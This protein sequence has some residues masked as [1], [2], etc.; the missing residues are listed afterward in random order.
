MILMVSCRMIIKNFLASLDQDSAFLQ[1]ED[2]QKISKIWTQKYDNRGTGFVP[3]YRVRTLVTD[4][5]KPLGLEGVNSKRKTFL[6]VRE[7]LRRSCLYHAQSKFNDEI[8]STV[9]S[10]T[11]PGI[12]QLF[13]S[14]T[15]LEVKL[16]NWVAERSVTP[17]EVAHSGEVLENSAEVSTSDSRNQSSEPQQ[18][19]NA[20]L[21][22]GQSSPAH[23]VS[24]TDQIVDMPLLL[25]VRSTIDLSGEDL[26]GEQM[27]SARVAAER[28]EN[29]EM[30]DGCPPQ[31]EISESYKNQVSIAQETAD[32]ISGL[33]LFENTFQDGTAKSTLLPALTDKTSQNIPVSSGTL[34]NELV[35]DSVVDG[36]VESNHH[37]FTYSSDSGK[38]Q[39][40]PM[41]E[42]QD[43]EK[44]IQKP[45]SVD[46]KSSSAEGTTCL[47]VSRLEFEAEACEDE[48]TL[49]PTSEA[50]VRPGKRVSTSSRDELEDFTISSRTNIE[51]CAGKAAGLVFVMRILA[52]GA[53]NCIIAVRWTVSLFLTMRARQK[54]I[55]HEIRF[56]KFV[57][58]MIYWN[59]EQKVIP[60]ELIESRRMYDDS[61]LR[62]AARDIVVSFLRGLL[63][64]RRLRLNTKIQHLEVIDN[65]ERNAAEDLSENLN[66]PGNVLSIDLE[67]LK[68]QLDLIC[69]FGYGRNLRM[70]ANQR[71]H[72]LLSIGEVGC[73]EALEIAEILNDDNIRIILDFVL[74][75]NRQRNHLDSKK[76]EILGLES[77]LAQLNAEKDEL[78]SE[79]RNVQDSTLKLKQEQDRLKSRELSYKAL[80]LKAQNEP[81][82][83][84]VVSTGEFTSEKEHRNY[85]GQVIDSADQEN[86]QSGDA[87]I[88]DKR[89]E[90][91]RFLTAKKIEQEI[92]KR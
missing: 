44:K 74:A 55:I 71:G 64:R 14:L 57:N 34:G 45:K 35:T 33:A 77:D 42:L 85:S 30:D 32:K 59:K 52:V 39:T 10:F 25:S 83:S 78:I 68:K 92:A 69:Q 18:P 80:L 2:V 43:T 3:L 58:A 65:F 84:Q 87:V 26:C 66:N 40:N 36:S 20:E 28:A 49:H 16:K 19:L 13:H 37:P 38:V 22:L 60:R 63:G 21:S 61:I 89:N 1:I 82:E 17:M 56:D 86:T 4:I 41:S 9:Q 15:N 8:L 50:L 70:A 48:S 73:L 79:L 27:L 23:E 90:E 11:F 7:D 29:E 62:L 54:H 91:K 81:N 51:K 12:S 5:P 46:G 53:L 24:N 72:G 6:C 88:V 75:R 47:D 67:S 76:S 31:D